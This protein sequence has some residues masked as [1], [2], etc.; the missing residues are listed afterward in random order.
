MSKT[1]FLYSLY[2][3]SDVCIYLQSVF[4]VNDKDVTLLRT[5]LY[6]IHVSMNEIETSIVLNILNNF[7]L[8][9]IC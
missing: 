5:K 9:I 1:K 4:S 6:C 8:A 7:S 2:I 3:Y